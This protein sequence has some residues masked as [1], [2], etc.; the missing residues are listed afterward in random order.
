MFSSKT[1]H[2]FSCSITAST[3]TVAPLTRVAPASFWDTH[4]VRFSASQGKWSMIACCG[5]AVGCGGAS[6]P[7]TNKHGNMTVQWLDLGVVVCVFV[8]QFVV[9][10]RVKTRSGEETFSSREQKTFPTSCGYCSQILPSNF[11]WSIGISDARVAPTNEKSVSKKSDTTDGSTPC[12]GQLHAPQV[13]TSVS[14]G[15]QQTIHPSC[16]LGET[17]QLLK[18]TDQQ[19]SPAAISSHPKTLGDQTPRELPETLPWELLL[20]DHLAMTGR[21][22][23]KISMTQDSTILWSKKKRFA[24]LNSYFRFL[25][26]HE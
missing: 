15:N 26:L 5:D 12:P 10:S 25:I 13:G 24:S 4:V 19:R 20:A 14:W 1:S 11:D 3:I 22:K 8:V 21:F 7:T 6:Q 23:K 16:S 2:A 17:T 18:P 9:P